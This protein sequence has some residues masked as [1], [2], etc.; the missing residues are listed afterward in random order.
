MSNNAVE[1][2]GS[3]TEETLKPFKS[4]YSAAAPL[5]SWS[6]SI[7]HRYLA[8]RSA[9]QLS[10]RFE[11]NLRNRIEA[12]QALVVPEGVALDNFQDFFINDVTAALFDAMCSK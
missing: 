12:H 10:Q 7:I 2:L 4:K 9:F 8:S 1:R 6:S 11:N 3:E 5:Y